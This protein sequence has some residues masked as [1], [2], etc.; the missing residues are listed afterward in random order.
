MKT[1]SLTLSPVRITHTMLFVAVVFALTFVMRLIGPDILGEGVIAL[2][3][4]VPIGWCTVRWGQ[5][6]GVSAALTA[7][8]SFDFLFIPPYRTF[9]IG[10]PEGEP[11]KLVTAAAV[12]LHRHG[13]PGGRTDPVDPHRGA[14]TRAQGHLFV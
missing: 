14:R 11:A 6:A 4:L 8:L 9:N 12:P 3:Y 1:V 5:I 13:H 10:S 2:L 7:A